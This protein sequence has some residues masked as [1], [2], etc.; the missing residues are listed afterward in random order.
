LL[1]E[2]VPLRGGDDSVGAWV[3][4]L[5]GRS[6]VVVAVAAERAGRATPAGY[7]LLRRATALADQLELPLVSLVDTAGADPLPDSEHAGVAAAI[8]SALAAVLACASPTIAVVHG[9]G[10]S[11]GALAAAV[12]DLVAVSAE[13]WFAALSPEG[14]AAALRREP[15]EA[16][17]LMR[18]S[19]AELAADGFADATAPSDPIALRGWLAFI[20]DRLGAQDPVVRRQLRDRRWRGPLHPR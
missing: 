19:P 8:A 5:D 16:A 2:R 11:G 4:L 12:C 7:Q 10:G 6:V 9:E 1:D 18:V 20:L 17:D 3:G 14:A 13:G 15:A